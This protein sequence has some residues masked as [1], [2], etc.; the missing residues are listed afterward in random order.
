M[1]NRIGKCQCSWWALAMSN[2]QR[3][4]IHSM[5]IDHE[6]W[7][8]FWKLYSQQT[9]QKISF[10][11]YELYGVFNMRYTMCKRAVSGILNE[12]NCSTAFFA[13]EF[14]KQF[15]KLVSWY[16][17]QTSNIILLNCSTVFSVQCTPFTS[18][19]TKKRINDI[20]WKTFIPQTDPN[21]NSL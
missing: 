12:M 1:I 20:K 10:C 4:M 21:M 6:L 7:F 14:I 18:N 3:A 9:D 11:V 13:Y 2:E 15:S 8:F 19:G 16:C 17:G 5:R